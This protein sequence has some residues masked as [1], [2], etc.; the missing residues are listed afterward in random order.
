[1]LNY[2]GELLVETGELEAARSKFEMAISVS[3]GKFA[4]AH[5]NQASLL[6]YGHSQPGEVSAI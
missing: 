6:L 1:M 5:V 2:H 3:G 4:L